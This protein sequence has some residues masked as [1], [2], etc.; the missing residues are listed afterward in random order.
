MFA[1]AKNLRLTIL[2]IMTL[3]SGT[4]LRIF[5][6]NWC[7]CFCLD[8][9]ER[10]YISE[11][12]VTTKHNIR[13]HNTQHHGMRHVRCSSDSKLSRR[14]RKVLRKIIFSVARMWE[15][16]VLGAFAKLRKAT[17]SFVKSV[18]QSVRTQGTTRLPLDG[19]SW[20]FIF[21]ISSKIYRENSS[22]IKIGQE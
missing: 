15:T 2:C 4:W 3:Q 9:V 21:N 11:I 19:F 17:I 7:L 10:I 6:E 12:L 20:N 22:F 1:V 14:F 5:R 8:N 18:R 16:P 13:C